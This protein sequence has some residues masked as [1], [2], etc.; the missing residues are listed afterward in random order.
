MEWVKLSARPAFYLDGALLR[1]GEAAEVLFV[2]GLAHCGSVE[3]G[4]RIDKTVVPM[5]VQTKVE[6]RANALCR[7]GLWSDEGAHYLVRSW[8]KHQDSHDIEVDRRRSDRDRKRK[9]RERRKQEAGQERDTSRDSPVT[10]RGQSDDVTP[11]EVEVEV[12]VEKDTPPRKRGARTR[13]AEHPSFAAFWDAYPR[14][15]VRTKAVESYAVAVTLT[16]P[17]VLTAAAQRYAA[18]NRDTDP[19]KIAHATTWLNQERWTD[20]PARPLSVAPDWR[21]LSD[22]ERQANAQTRR[23]LQRVADGGQMFPGD[24][25]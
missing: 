20:E 17:E 1:A 19:T 21:D 6:A 5:L 8:V 2:R 22:A 9:E 15:V 7:E 18:A 24:V 4:G 10:S 11:L 12:E 14:H 16:S 13:A 3:S 25:A 23:M